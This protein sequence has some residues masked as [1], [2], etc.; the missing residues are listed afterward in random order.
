MSNIAKQ[1]KSKLY[2]MQFTLCSINEQILN[3]KSHLAILASAH[4]HSI[5]VHW[6][7]FPLAYSGFMIAY[8][9]AFDAQ[10]FLGNEFFSIN[11][12]QTFSHF[13][14]Y[15]FPFLAIKIQSCCSSILPILVVVV[16]WRNES[17]F[18]SFNK[19]LG[20]FIWMYLVSFHFD[21]DCISFGI[22][23]TSW[24]LQGKF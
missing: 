24:N 10:A 8:S 2:G 22:F 16:Y 9:F 17:V 19:W 21:S 20:N 13:E 11:I 23:L 18:I 5:L 3:I 1:C 15:T 6:I 4:I 7:S 14:S 12:V